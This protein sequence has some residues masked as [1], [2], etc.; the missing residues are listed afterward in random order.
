MGGISLGLVIGLLVVLGAGG[1]A[2]W[3]WKPWEQKTQFTATLM[4]QPVKTDVFV[5][6]VT[7]QGEVESSSNTEVMCEVQSKNSGGITI[8]EVVPEG[9]NVNKG[10]F[11]VRFDSSALQEE[12]SQQL[13]VCNSSEAAMIQAENVLNTAQISKLEYL[14]GTFRQDQQLI[15]SEMSVAEENLRRA[16][17]YLQHSHKLAAKGYVTE[18]QLEADRFAVDKAKMDVETAKTKLGV[19]REYTKAKMTSQL[20]ADIKT[21]EAN[22]KSQLS[23]HKLDMDKLTHIEEQIKKC[24]IFAPSDG[25]VVYANQSDRRGSSDFI[26]EA[27]AIVRERQSLIR[28]PDPKRMQ[29]KAKINESRIDRVR[30]GQPALIR[31]DAFPET[32]LTGTV[33]KVDDYPLPGSW[34]SSSVKEYGT[35]VAIDAPPPGTRPGMSAEVKIRAEQL[36]DAMQIPVQ[37]VVE[38]KGHHFAL[39]RT[40]QGLDAREV[41]LGSTNDKFVVVKGGVADGDQVVMNPRKHLDRVTLPDLPEVASTQI[42][43]S[44]AIP[45][46]AGGVAK[47]AGTAPLDGSAKAQVALASTQDPTSEKRAAGE[48]GGERR[49][50]AGGGPPRDPA[51]MVQMIM[52]QDKNNDGKLSQDEVDERMR[53]RFSAMDA[54]GDG[55]IDRGELTTALARRMRAGGAGGGGGAVAAPSAGNSG[56]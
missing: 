40:A 4:L 38:H 6:E 10:D 44:K 45:E 2:L 8:I 12:R 53:G 42:L 22:L 37:A 16:E 24:E 17:D 43:A 41:E 54:N 26:V 34:F 50:E 9:T 56:L 52:S 33:I 13:I 18:L 20:E 25:Q 21:A 14:D 19:L 47:A 30:P 32:Q 5:Y 55:L 7:E 3:Y 28:L 51:A 36:P 1:G 15:L 48:P 49:R 35:L 29:V 39:V 31:L 11:L 27:G 23:I 46:A